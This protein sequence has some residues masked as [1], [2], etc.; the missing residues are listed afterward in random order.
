MIYERDF[1]TIPRFRPRYDYRRSF[2]KKNDVKINV[3][4]PSGNVKAEESVE[5]PKSSLYKWWLNFCENSSIH[6]LRY[7][8]QESLHWFERWREK[9]Y[10][11][12]Q[13]NILLKNR[14]QSYL[15]YSRHLRH[16]QHHLHFSQAF[17][18][19]F[20]LS[21][22]NSCW[23]NDFS[24]FK[25]SFSSSFN[26]QPQQIS[27]GKMR[28]STGKVFAECWQRNNW[29]FQNSSFINERSRVWSVWWIPGRHFQ[30]HFTRTWSFKFNRN[31][32]VCDAEVWGNFCGKVLV[33]EQSKKI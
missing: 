3:I 21:T 16:F 20:R 1:Q 9:F 31:F 14:F 7:I 19:I 28:R 29:D 15:Q 6:G 26:L 30:F 10:E 2:G 32:W 4:S 23:I 12:K 18:K 24:S 25:H 27:Q 13:S 5:D 22:F 8:G 11:F 33:E 17:P